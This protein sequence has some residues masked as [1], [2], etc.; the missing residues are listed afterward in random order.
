MTLLRMLVVARPFLIVLA[1]MQLGV[2]I[3]SILHYVIQ[4]LPK[5]IGVGT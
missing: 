3:F 2:V 5:E 1:M 4:M